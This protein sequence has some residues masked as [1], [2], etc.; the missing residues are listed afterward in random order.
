[1][2]RN[3]GNFIGFS[4]SP[5]AIVNSGGASG[6][7]DLIQQVYFKRLA[8][9][10]DSTVIAP[11]QVTGG[12][13]VTDSGY[14][15]HVFLSPG[16]LVDNTPITTSSEIEVLMVAGGGGAGA[17]LGAGGGGGGVVHHTQLLIQGD[18]TITVGSGGVGA[19]PTVTPAVGAP[20][21][22]GGDSTVTLTNGIVL[23]AMGGG[24][25]GRY[26]YSPEEQ[27]V[28]NQGGS[29]GGQPTTESPEPFMEITSGVGLQPTL[30]TV[31]QGT[32]GFN[33][34]GNPGG[35][36]IAPY[37][38]SDPY[39]KSG[40]GA[41]SAGTAANPGAGGAGQPFPAFAG[42]KFP[43]IPA[44]SRSE[45]GP[46]G[47]YGGGGGAGGRTTSGPGGPGGGGN[48]AGLPGAAPPSFLGTGE[49]GYQYTGGGGGG[50]RYT[51][52]SPLGLATGGSGIVIFRYAA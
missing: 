7:F 27:G 48:G 47:L 40:G 16:T 49:P 9:W 46:T 37:G 17:P 1:M 13:V 18:S 45:I 12:T 31:Y 22:R 24:G 6:I 4:T 2:V 43:M 42:P 52:V 30:N 19:S 44:P 14:K 50:G 35:V 32:A 5:Q 39:G 26:D 15:Y 3:I 11:P 10:P 41:G 23:T 51:T 33:Q 25:G 38:S 8:K 20:G 34:Y 21:G 28:S 36:V 29:G